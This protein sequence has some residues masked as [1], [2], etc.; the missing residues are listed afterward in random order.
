MLDE[1][2]GHA[3]AV[4]DGVDALQ[5]LRRLRGVHAGGRLIQQQHFHV[6][7]QGPGNLQLALLAIGQAGGQHIGLI[8]QMADGQKVHGLFRQGLFRPPVFGGAE[9][10]VQ[11]VVGDVLGK[12]G[13]HVFDDGHLPEQADVLEG[14][15]HP[16]RHELIGLFA[17][18]GDAV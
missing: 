7:G 17:V 8:L 9:G 15:G 10:G 5:Q 14:A 4:P 12:G 18:E 11:Q 1:E 13:L 3:E 16:C 2:N 6:R